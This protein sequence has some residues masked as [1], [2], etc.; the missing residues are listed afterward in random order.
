M[1]VSNT[2]FVVFIKELTVT[3]APN[4]YIMSLFLL[5][6]LCSSS[7]SSFIILVCIFTLSMDDDNLGK[8]VAGQ[9]GNAHLLVHH[10][11]ED[12]H[13]R[14]TSVV[15]FDGTLLHLGLCT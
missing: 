7:S 15:E 10:K 2:H 13:L 9:D 5:S 1:Y 11:A 8:D 6:S 3:T 4:Q 12:A 14:G